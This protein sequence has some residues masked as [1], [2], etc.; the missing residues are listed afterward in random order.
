[1]CLFVYDPQTQYITDLKRIICYI[2]GTLI[3][4]IHLSPFFIDNLTTYT[5]WGGRPDTRR[6]M[7]GYCVYLRDNLIS[8]Y[9]KRQTTFSRS[10]V[11]TEY[12]GVTN[13]VYESC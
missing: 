7:S 2:K 4:D 8:W 3:P 11:E 9:V 12:R 13:V 6:P 5:D 1:M 10:K